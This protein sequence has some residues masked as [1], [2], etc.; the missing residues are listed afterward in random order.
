MGIFIFILLIVGFAFVSY[1]FIRYIIP[2][3]FQLLAIF[4]YNKN[5]CIY[6]KIA[7]NK[8]KLL[9][10]PAFSKIDDSKYYTKQEVKD[11]FCY[12]EYSYYRIKEEFTYPNGRKTIRIT[13]KFEIVPN[14]FWTNML[15]EDNYR[16]F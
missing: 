7:D 10:Q 4:Y 11:L 16:L 3:P 5:R 9:S 6:D 8:Y 1:L 12:S 15:G 14:S 13:N 2:L